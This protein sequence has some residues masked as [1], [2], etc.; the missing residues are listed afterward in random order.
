MADAL[1]V[2]RLLLAACLP[3]LLLRRSPAALLVWG[4]AALTDFLDGRVARRRGGS[5]WGGVLDV[6]ADV[7][8][9]GGGLVAAA[10]VGLV[11]AVAPAA[12]A[13]SVAAYVLASVRASRAGG[14]RLAR[15]R[16]GHR[17]GIANWACVGL[18][19]GEA[20]VPGWPLDDLAFVAGAGVAAINMA[21]V[22]E[23]AFGR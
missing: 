17:A 21:A 23:R 2:V 19:A 13:C 11:P 16:L 1:S 8:F 9:V 18:V 15:S 4:V 12:V 3:A 20:A 14:I 5:R 7:A 22:A 10:V 6:V